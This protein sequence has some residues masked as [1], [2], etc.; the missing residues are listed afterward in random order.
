[1]PRK[2][3]K[4][5]QAP[6]ELEVNLDNFVIERDNNW[7]LVDGVEY[8]RVSWVNSF[9]PKGERYEMWL[10]DMPSY[11]EAIKY[12]DERGASGTKVHE[13]CELKIQGMALSYS[14]YTRNEQRMIEAFDKWRE[15][16]QPEIINYEQTVVSKDFFYAG[17]YDILCRIKGQLYIV[18]IKTGSIELESWWTQ[19]ASYIQ[20]LFEMGLV[21]EDETVLPAVLHLGVKNKKYFKFIESEKKWEDWFLIFLSVQSIWAHENPDPQPNHCLRA[22]VF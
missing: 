14:D 16:V 7:H 21:K 22:K 18:D 4:I 9:Y 8:P 12:R 19:Q 17:H 2:A 11:N 10:G 13:G 5:K 3:K 20:A 15:E 1:M 6:P